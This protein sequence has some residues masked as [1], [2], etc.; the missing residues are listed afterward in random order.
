MVIQKTNSNDYFRY[1]FLDSK[2]TSS[3]TNLE[4]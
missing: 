4:P 1:E 2:K 3:E